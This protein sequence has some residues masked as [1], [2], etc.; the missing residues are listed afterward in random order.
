VGDFRREVD[1]WRK[2]HTPRRVKREPTAQG[3]V[4]SLKRA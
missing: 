4:G 2:L 3:T 1:A